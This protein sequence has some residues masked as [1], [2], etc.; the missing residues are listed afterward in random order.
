MLAAHKRA[1]EHYIILLAMEAH[2]TGSDVKGEELVQ[3]FKDSFRVI[4]YTQH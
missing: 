4:S 3:N 1:K 2:E